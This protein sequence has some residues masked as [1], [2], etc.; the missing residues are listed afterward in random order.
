[1]YHT[2]NGSQFPHL[3]YYADRQKHVHDCLHPSQIYN[4]Y[5]FEIRVKSETLIIWLA[6]WVKIEWSI[7]H[8][9]FWHL[10]FEFPLSRSLNFSL[11]NYREL[12][13]ATPGCQ[14]FD[15]EKI[16]ENRS[17][18]FIST[19]RSK[20]KQAL[21]TSYFFSSVYMVTKFPKMSRIRIN[22]DCIV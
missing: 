18:R 14:S 9:N 3:S 1:M 4:I 16:C 7:F 22:L 15:L 8:S 6:V 20:H 2:S 17:R 13:D 12:T 5:L 11:P 10:N 21:D 19:R